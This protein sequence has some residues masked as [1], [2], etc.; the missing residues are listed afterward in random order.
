M[1]A[2]FTWRAPTGQGINV[3]LAFI[4]IVLF[5]VCIAPESIREYD[6]EIESYDNYANHN[7]NSELRLTLAV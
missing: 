2:L 3:P 7:H 6:D 1:L 4:V 5:N